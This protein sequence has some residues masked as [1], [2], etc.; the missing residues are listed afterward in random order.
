MARK[1]KPWD[2]KVIYHNRNRMSKEGEPLAQATLIC[3]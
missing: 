1:T 3:R 2:M